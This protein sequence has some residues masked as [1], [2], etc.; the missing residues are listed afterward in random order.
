MVE[1][2]LYIDRTSNRTEKERVYAKHLLFFLYPKNSFWG[3]LTSPFRLAIAHISPISWLYGLWQHLPWTKGKIK[4]F[5]KSFQIDLQECIVPSGGYKNFHQFFT[6]KLKQD[7]RPFTQDTKSAII[8]ADGRYRFYPHLS[9]KEFF[10]IKNQKLNLTKLLQDKELND[11]YENGSCIIAR[12]APADYHRFHFP[13]TGRVGAAKPIKGS[14]YSVH[15][16]ALRKDWSVLWKNKRTITQIESPIFGKVLFIAVGATNIGSIHQTFVPDSDI[17]MGQEKGYFSFGA[18]CLIILFR[19]NSIQFDKD[20]LH[21][22]DR[23]ILCKFGQSM[24][25][26]I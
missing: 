22:Q 7:A 9:S 14:L 1:E 24:G 4:P 17:L 6:R 26:A 20:L 21:N 18:S 2:I 19:K 3:F 15:P 12:L 13:I 8:P 10:S 25:R 23:E 16:F 11:L 5:V